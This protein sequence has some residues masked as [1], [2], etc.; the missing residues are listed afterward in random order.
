MDK[1]LSQSGMTKVSKNGIEHLVILHSGFD[2]LVYMFYLFKDVLLMFCLLYYTG[3]LH[4][5]SLYPIMVLCC[6]KSLF[7]EMFYLDISYDGAY[8]GSNGS[9]LH[10][11]II[12]TLDEKNMCCGSKALTVYDWLYCTLSP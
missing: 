8:W 12:I 4:I 10:L 6:S 5:P 9:S 1:V 11:F 7:F 3:I 2:S